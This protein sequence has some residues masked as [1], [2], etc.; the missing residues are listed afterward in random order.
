MSNSAT[1]GSDFLCDATRQ[2]KQILVTD[3]AEIARETVSAESR[4]ER[5]TD[6]PSEFA[7]KRGLL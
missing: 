4:G 5:E 6:K 7:M 1:I 3:A 2:W